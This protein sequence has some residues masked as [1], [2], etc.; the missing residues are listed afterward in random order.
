MGGS[1]FLPTDTSSTKANLY[2]QA[3]SASVG[4]GVTGALSTNNGARI[5]LMGDDGGFIRTESS[6]FGIFPQSDI[7]ST[8]QGTLHV[9][10]ARYS[11]TNYVSNG[12]FTSDLSSWTITTGGQTVERTSAGKL[13]IASSSAFASAHQDITLVD[14]VR[15]KL[16]YD[17]VITSGTGY[18]K[19]NDGTDDIPIQQF[20]STGSYTHYFT[21]S[22]GTFRL[23]F[24]RSTTPATL[25]LITSPL[26]K[27]PSPPPQIF[28]STLPP[29]IWL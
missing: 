14:G 29:M 24:A 23:M 9:S 20:N 11:T 6:G 15:Y 22:S 16:T 1:I 28:Q 12:T 27:T 2:I 13:R 3:Q 21:H 18:V 10:T 26:L 4:H 19:D 17:A 25:R 8:I 5:R 7:D